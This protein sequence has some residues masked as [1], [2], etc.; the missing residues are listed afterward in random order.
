MPLSRKSQ[1]IV[2]HLTKYSDS[3]LVVHA[4][5]SSVG[6]CSFFLRGVGKK[7]Q[8]TL[9]NFHSLSILD[10]IALDNSKSSLFTL[11]EYSSAYNLSTLRADPIKGAIALFISEVLYR[12]MHETNMEESL[13]SWLCNSIKTLNDIDGKIA[14]FHLWFLVG[15]CSKMGFLPRNNFS[16]INRIFQIT[17]EEFISKQASNSLQDIF[18]EESSFIL[19]KFLTLPFTEAMHLQLTSTQRNNFAIKIIEYLSYHL[20]ITINIKSLSVL[21]DIFATFV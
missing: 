1:I 12:C 7:R 10:T 20:G 6:R 3:G 16:E 4:L 2:L 11:Q 18:S 19:H 14:N 13:F 21:H 5:D 9:A 17:T 8:S 15:L